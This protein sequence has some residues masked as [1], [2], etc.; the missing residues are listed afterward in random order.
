MFAI[1]EHCAV[2]Y[3][4]FRI[5]NRSSILEDL[6]ITSQSILIASFLPDS[7]QPIFFDFLIAFFI[8]DYFLY[9]IAKVRLQSGLLPLLFEISTFHES[10]PWKKIAF[11][12]IY[13]TAGSLFMEFLPPISFPRNHMLAL[14]AGIGLAPFFFSTPSTR[15]SNLFFLW[16]SDLIRRFSFRRHPRIGYPI[17]RSEKSTP[18]ENRRFHIKMKER[19][20]PHVIFLFLESFRAKN[21]GCLGCSLNLTPSFDKWSKEGILFSQFHSNGILTSYSMISSLFGIFPM[22]RSCYLHPYLSIPLRGIP[23]I[24]RENGYENGMILGGPESFQSWERFFKVND[25]QEVIGKKRILAEYPNAESTS[26]GVHD[27]WIYRKA[28]SWLESKSKPV[29]LT[30]LTATN[31]H[32]WST[33]S[34]WHGPKSREDYHETFAYA[35]WALGEWLKAMDESGLMEKSLIF[36]FGDHGQGMGERGARSLVNQHLYQENIHIPLLLLAKGRIEKPLCFSDPC[37]QVDLLPTILDLLRIESTHHGMGQSLV[38]KKRSK[39][40]FFLHPFQES[41]IALREGT[42][43]CILNLSSGKKELFNL[44]KDPKEGENLSAI[45]PALT[46]EMEKKAV[47]QLDLSNTLYATKGFTLPRINKASLDLDFSKT[48]FTKSTLLKLKKKG[49]QINSLNFS[50]QLFVTDEFL[51]QHSN[52]WP[53][54]S[55]IDLSHCVLVADAGIN[56]LLHSCKHLEEIHLHGLDELTG[57]VEASPKHLRILDL[58][59]C[60][61]LEAAPTIRWISKLDSLSTFGIDGENFREADWHHLFETLPHISLLFIQNGTHLKAEALS[62]LWIKNLSLYSIAFENCFELTDECFA[63]L[64]NHNLQ[65]LSLSSCPKVTGRTLNKLQDLSLRTLSIKNCPSIES[66]AIEYWQQKGIKI[67]RF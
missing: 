23:Q 27:E 16:E 62:H 13:T 57:C 43:K 32:P 25:F 61:S 46:K 52:F 60:K 7:F 65:F 3:L 59:H 48:R 31:H 10:I 54:L 38:L 6:G 42:W 4:L 39:S 45:H 22:F 33:P 5:L 26:W 15:D 17:L 11:F 34:S 1:F 14:F 47:A 21:V 8:G 49:P 55:K 44:E 12:F 35:D 51:S 20:K 67:L 58:L 9:K 50:H 37:S 56:A 30:L 36:I 41:L 28:H 18:D 19:E 64:K 53:Y 63:S 66:S 29:F 2:V 40:Q 24:L